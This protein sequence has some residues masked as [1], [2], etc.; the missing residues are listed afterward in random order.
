MFS[1]VLSLAVLASAVHASPVYFGEHAGGNCSTGPLTRIFADNGGCHPRDDPFTGLT[2]FSKLDCISA[3]IAV[4]LDFGANST[5]SGTPVSTTDIPLGC[6]GGSQS[7]YCS[8]PS[9]DFSG[10]GS[11]RRYI[12]DST[13]N[14]DADAEVTAFRL[15]ECDSWGPDGS[16]VHRCVDGRMF[17][18]EYSPD[19]PTCIG[20][21]DREFSYVDGQ[22]S[23][24]PGKPYSV[25]AT[26]DLRAFNNEPALP[27]PSA[28]EMLPG[29][30]PVK[31]NYLDDACTT[32]MY[33]DAYANGVR[34][35]GSE[36]G[37]SRVTC[38]GDATSPQAVFESF[39]DFD[40]DF[41][42]FQEFV[43]ESC[44]MIDGS[45]A[46]VSCVPE[47]DLEST[48][49]APTSADVS[50]V[51]GGYFGQC[52]GLATKFRTMA[53]EQC[54]PMRDG[55]R[56]VRQMSHGPMVMEF[57]STD[58]SPGTIVN[59]FDFTPSYCANFGDIHFPEFLRNL[60]GNMCQAPKHMS[61]RGFTRG[62]A[63]NCESVVPPVYYSFEAG[64]FLTRLPELAKM[65]VTGS[66]M[67]MFVDDSE[68]PSSMDGGSY[69]YIVSDEIADTLEVPEWADSCAPWDA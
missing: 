17:V 29:F 69:V 63:M 5:C 15:N 65:D 48:M 61:G 49:C 47:S 56:L 22:C 19:N 33:K 28:V 25:Q 30:V 52:T 54:M 6:S 14:V 26:C 10:F 12:G 24:V 53:F 39:T 37:L 9:T 36:D 58:C 34:Q 41:P 66:P 1:W 8:I 4:Q 7:M 42:V 62:D 60:G 51:L 44:A 40:S 20:T 21:P 13:C 57:S 45:Y 18:S 11:F 46:T 55:S 16:R 67:V 43:T 64:T 32:V 2:S 31:V 59:E 27:P 35:L 50:G 3:S 38:T 23:N 68:P